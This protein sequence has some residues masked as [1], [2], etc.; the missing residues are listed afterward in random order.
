[1]IKPHLV[2]ISPALAKANNGNWQTAARWARL[3]REHY[4][5]T[6]VAES[7]PLTSDSRPAAVIALHARRSA[8]ALSVLYA[9]WPAM[10][11]V[12]VLTGTDLYRD[13]ANDPTAQRC[14]QTAT[15]LVVLQPAA[16]TQLEPEARRKASVIYQSAPALKPIH[17]QAR[18]R[19]FDVV[20]IGHLRSEKRPQTL[21]Q[22]AALVTTPTIRFTH[23][24]GALDAELG[25]QAKACD[26]AQANYRWLGALPHGATRQL[27]KRQQLMVIT[28]EMEGGAN[29]IC[30]ALT[31]G[32]A[33]AASDINGNRGMLGDD[34]QGYFPL[35]DS[36]ALARLIERAAT[37][38][39]FY[40]GLRRQCDRRAPLFAPE[41]EKFLLLQLVDNLLSDAANPKQAK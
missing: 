39:A 16:L 14:V 4:R 11:T 41:R 13:L 32:V 25:R 37:E 20:M 19:H 7:H 22:A 21:I 17:W 8:P 34:Y 3:L 9:A 29:V 28:S 18:K 12:L 5:I 6:I 36:H 35:G 31:S 33:V 10:P 38:P 30:E 24:G 26:L 23:I 40:A 27:L 2:I 1:M 15:R